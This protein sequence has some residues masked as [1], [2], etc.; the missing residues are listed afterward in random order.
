MILLSF[1]TRFVFMKKESSANICNVEFSWLMSSVS[2]SQRYRRVVRMRT[3]GATWIFIWTKRMRCWKVYTSIG[4]KID[5]TNIR[6]VFSSSYYNHEWALSSLVLHPSPPTQ[7]ATFPSRGRDLEFWGLVF[8]QFFFASYP[9]PRLGQRENASGMKLLADCSD[10]TLSPSGSIHEANLIETREN[11]SL[12]GF[13]II[14]S[15]SFLWEEDFF[16][17]KSKQNI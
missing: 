7:P 13:Y 6:D 11:S 16:L 2:V 17:L 10:T 9:K 12:N 1:K 15:Y 5:K 8:S 3:V 4:C 14:L